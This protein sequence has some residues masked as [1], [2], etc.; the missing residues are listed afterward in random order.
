M[1]YEVAMTDTLALIDVSS[2]GRTVWV[3]G[4]MGCLARFCK[5]SAEYYGDKPQTVKNNP[6]NLKQSWEDFVVNIGIHFNVDVSEHKP[7][8]VGQVPIG[9]FE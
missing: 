2:D 3:N 4:Q 5:Y 9:I 1:S 6:E 7:N 8:Y